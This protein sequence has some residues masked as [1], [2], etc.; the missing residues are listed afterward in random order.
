LGQPIDSAALV[1]RYQSLPIK[2]Q[3]ELAVNGSDLLEAGIPAGPSI[4]R[5]LHRI[6]V[7]VLDGKVNNDKD[8]ILTFLSGI[9]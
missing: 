5:Y 8:S 6:L 7:A 9:D 2:Q 1:D 4:G 3:R